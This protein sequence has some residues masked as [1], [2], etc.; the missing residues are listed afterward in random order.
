[1]QEERGRARHYRQRR[2]VLRPRLAAE[3][4]AIGTELKVRIVHGVYKCTVDPQ[5]SVV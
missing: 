5:A 2:T 1:M 3:H 4:E